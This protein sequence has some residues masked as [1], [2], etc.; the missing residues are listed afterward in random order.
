MAAMDL[1]TVFR[2][3]TQ[4]F[5]NE[6]AITLSRTTK[7]VLASTYAA[8]SNERDLADSEGNAPVGSST[9]DATLKAMSPSD[10]RM[11]KVESLRAAIAEGTYCV[12]SSDVAD[13]LMGRML[14]KKKATGPVSKD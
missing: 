7:A 10:V 3:G 9:A 12:S 8:S 14:N 4:G 13:K 1:Q 2:S 6:D 5:E 11:D